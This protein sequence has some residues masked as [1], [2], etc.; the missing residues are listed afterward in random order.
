MSTFEL[1]PR[2]PHERGWAGVRER[3][4]SIPLTAPGALLIA[5]LVLTLFAAFAHGAVQSPA[6]ARLQVAIAAVAA[7]AGG[8]LLW[9]GN[10][11]LA[12]PRMAWT[13]VGLL[14]AFAIW[15]GISLAWSVLPN[16]TWIELNR[17]IAYVIV[18]VLA[19]A[20]GSSTRRAAELAADGFLVVS[21]AVAV[22]A[23]A[24]KLI[25]GV[26]IS[27][28]FNLNQTG[29]LSRLQEPFGYWNALA[30]FA[31]MGVPVALWIAVEGDRRGRRL[32]GLVLLEL[33]FLLIAFTYSRGA[34]IAL[35]PA[36]AIAL[37]LG[38]N[39]LRGLLWLG[40][41][42]ICAA[43]PMILGLTSHSLSVS[44][45]ALSHR[46]SAGAKLLGVLVVSLAALLLAGM[47]VM[48]LESRVRLSPARARGVARALVTAF[49]LGCLIA[50]VIVAF[51]HR[52]LTGTISHVWHRFTVSYDVRANDPSHLFSA[53]SGHR[54]GWWKE[55]LGAFGA[56]PL[57]GWGAG[58]FPVVD[59]LY[60]HDSL[61][62]KQPHNVPLQWL[63]ETGLVGAGLALAG[64]VLLAIVAVRAVQRR[65]PGSQRM[66]AAALLAA[67]V[68]YG[69]HALYDW[70]SDIPG[71]TLPAILFLGVLIGI[72]GRSSARPPAGPRGVLLEIPSELSPRAGM[73]LAGLAVIT[74][75]L[76]CYAASAAIPS[77]AADRARSALVAADGNSRSELLS[78]ARSAASASRL[79][80]LSDAG[81]L[82]ESTIALRLRQP[83]AARSLLLAAVKRQPA[84]PQ[85]WTSLAI[86]DVQLGDARDALSAV[87]R[88]LALDPR[89]YHTALIAVQLAFRAAELQ[90]PPQDSAAATAT[91]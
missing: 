60:R 71:V 21:F 78:A 73:R 62:V 11:R 68:A 53:D 15:S 70:D 30:L 35:V 82:A 36:V 17:E 59:L 33:E 12:M 49:G 9:R 58:S 57:Q 34:L 13:G 3:V 38:G 85:A 26:H 5:L 31:S 1:T 50:L 6:E 8:A 22:Y 84:D 61:T 80:P 66:V 32:A 90:T 91:P 20:V 25:P 81:L 65:P 27:G 63:S 86:V 16:G 69:V 47:R 54:W 28:L 89:D 72:R 39:R 88:A 52:G 41:A 76:C 14:G 64:C 40:V 7:A 44:H 67:V 18:L 87:Q 77:I 23:L 43:P 74:L 75:L 45:V 24:Q 83:V 79:D 19:I 51:S 56:R 2:S 46:E 4:R 42:G 37:A 10:L 55:A 29:G 48:A